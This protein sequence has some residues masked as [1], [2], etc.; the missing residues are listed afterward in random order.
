MIT[1]ILSSDLFKKK[2]KYVHLKARNLCCVD[3]IFVCSNTSFWNFFRNKSDDQLY[4]Y[5]KSILKRRLNRHLGT[6]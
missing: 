4:L 3:E 1:Y 2:D 6:L 5:I